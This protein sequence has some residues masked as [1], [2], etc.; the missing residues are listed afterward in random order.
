MPKDYL[1]EH[2]IR[3]IHEFAMSHDQRK[4]LSRIFGPYTPMKRH[5]EIMCRPLAQKKLQAVVNNAVKEME[6]SSASSLRKLMNIQNATLN[7]FI[8]LKTGD[9]KD[10]IPQEYMD[11]VKSVNYDAK[12]GAVTQ[13]TLVD[14]LKAIE[15]SLKFTGML[16]KKID[17]NVNLSITEQ[18][19]SSTVGDEE[20]DDFIKNLLSKPKE[21]EVIE[22][23][24][25][26][27]E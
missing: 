21:L 5:D 3:Y 9:F 4:S 6:K 19:A 20:V 15:T 27:D 12:T 8:D 1:T 22:V 17:V 10:D 24:E 2:D 7:D 16:N 26:Y 23:Q 11:A 18:I 14:K 13:V 25:V